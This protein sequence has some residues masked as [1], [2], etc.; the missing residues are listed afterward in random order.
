MKVIARSAQEWCDS[1]SGVVLLFSC[2][3]CYSLPVLRDT[4][5]APLFMNRADGS[6]EHRAPCACLQ[7]SSN[8]LASCYWHCKWVSNA[9]IRG[10]AA[11]RRP[12]PSIVASNR[13]FQRW[14]LRKSGSRTAYLNSLYIRSVSFE[15]HHI[16][17]KQII[18]IGSKWTKLQAKK[19]DL[20]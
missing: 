16:S 8:S 1:I 7:R 14:I 4:D 6:R 3:F 12:R 20:Y 10:S 15:D 11:I 13:L 18:T 5:L 9:A 2:L 19:K 17:T